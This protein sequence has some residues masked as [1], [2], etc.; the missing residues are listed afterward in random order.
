MKRSSVQ[1]IWQ[2]KF[3]SIYLIHEGHVIIQ[4]FYCQVATAGK[5]KLTDVLKIVSPCKSP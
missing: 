3:Y 2:R 5:T 1:Q 4:A